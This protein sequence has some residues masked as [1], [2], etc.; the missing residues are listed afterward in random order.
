[1]VSG[2]PTEQSL[3]SSP[4][5][6]DTEAGWQFSGSVR[7]REKQKRG[8]ELCRSSCASADGS[9]SAALEPLAF[10]WQILPNLGLVA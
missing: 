1:M 9:D 2:Q 7:V 8:P 5:K 10:P 3:T 4:P 6:A